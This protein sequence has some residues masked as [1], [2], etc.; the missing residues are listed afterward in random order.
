M[1]PVAQI[2]F[3]T[4]SAAVKADIV[5]RRNSRAIDI[6]LLCYCRSK[7]SCGSRLSLYHRMIQHDAVRNISCARAFEQSIAFKR[8]QKMVM[9]SELRR[10]RLSPIIP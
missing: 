4:S 5:P 2:L 7:K 8:V 9:A 10:G 3:V 6:A 1:L